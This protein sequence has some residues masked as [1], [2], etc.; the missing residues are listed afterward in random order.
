MEGEVTV[1]IEAAGKFT[2]TPNDVFAVPGWSRWRTT[3]GP[4]SDAVLFAYSDRPVYEKLGLYRE[5]RG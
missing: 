3:A 5:Q 4:G 2:V 1:E